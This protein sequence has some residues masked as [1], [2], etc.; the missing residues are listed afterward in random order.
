MVKAKQYLVS[1][2][3]KEGDATTLR[4]MSISAP[5][6]WLAVD[7]AYRKLARLSPTF[8]VVSIIPTPSAQGKMQAQEV[9]G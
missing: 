7:E 9:G 4:S 1:Y 5:S 8:T 3:A 2:L 6:W